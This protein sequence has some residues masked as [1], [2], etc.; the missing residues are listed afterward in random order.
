MASEIKANTY[1]DFNSNPVIVSDGS[2]NVTIGSSGKTIT[3]SGTA[4]GFG[5]T[6]TPAFH[7]RR[8]SSQSIP[9]AT[10]TIMIFD[11]EQFDTNSAYNTAT[12]TFTVPSEE[13]GKYCV[14]FGF[15]RNNW[16][17]NRFV[18]N[19]FRA[20]NSAYAGGDL[21]VTGVYSGGYASNVIILSAGDTVRV[22]VYH[23]NGSTQSIKGAGSGTDETFFGAYKLII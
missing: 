19:L 20:D 15:R 8:T 4:V 9:N 6:N 18:Y 14:Y 17:S 11:T 13:G 21:T 5:G 2:G 3:N 12:G 16:Q 1:N 22:G 23:D 7:A 10:D